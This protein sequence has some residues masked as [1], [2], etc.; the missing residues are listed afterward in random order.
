MGLGN[1]NLKRSFCFFYHVYF[2]MEFF[3]Y[4]KNLFCVELT[5]YL[6][7]ASKKLK[8]GSITLNAF[9]Q[10]GPGQLAFFN[11]L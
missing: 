4:F 6:Y 11:I 5:D 8:K 7:C 3:F 1:L 9:I 2:V 10:R